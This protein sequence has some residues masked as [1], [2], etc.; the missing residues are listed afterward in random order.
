[1]VHHASIFQ[2]EENK[3]SYSAS[4]EQVTSNRKL[5]DNSF[6]DDGTIPTDFV[7]VGNSTNRGVAM[8]VV[9]VVVVAVTDRARTLFTL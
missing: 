8:V 2:E 9:V 6:A 4:Q 3:F 1:M 5:L 7:P